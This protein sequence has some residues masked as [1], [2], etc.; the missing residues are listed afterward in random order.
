MARLVIFDD[1]VR[2]VELPRR[3]VFIGRSKKNDIPINDELLSRKHCSI[4][5]LERGYRLLDLKSSNG[6]FLNG[7]RAD[8]VDLAVDDVIELGNTVM[9]FLEDGMWSRGEGLAKVRNPLKAQELIG[10][11]RRHHRS[12]RPGLKIPHVT[13]PAAPGAEDP[14]RPRARKASAR[15][16]ASVNWGGPDEFLRAVEDFL[17]HKAV[18]LLSRSHPTLRRLE[19]RVLRELFAA[20]EH[21]AADRLVGKGGKPAPPADGRTLR[22]QIRGLLTQHR[23]AFVSIWRGLTPA[24]GTS[25]ELPPGTSERETKDHGPISP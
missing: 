1:R 18:A 22:E 8:K 15:A 16:P 20:T 12:R 9:V 19:A 13:L 24:S 7:R 6:T 25:T 10:R 17:T 3:A 14:D 4:V 21:L 11:L 5:P 2:G 23:A